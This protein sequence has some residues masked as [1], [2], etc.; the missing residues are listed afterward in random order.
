MDAIQKM[1]AMSLVLGL[2]GGGLWWLRRKGLAQF[3][4]PGFRK[5]ERKMQVVEKLPLSP[6][7]SLHLV[8]VGGRTLLVASSPGGCALLEAS[9][10]DGLPRGQEPVR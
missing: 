9:A 2:L 3:S 7:H 5:C 8:R 6:G 1:L 10:G 4:H